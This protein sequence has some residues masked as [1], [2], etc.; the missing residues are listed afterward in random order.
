MVYFYRYSQDVEN[1]IIVQVFLICLSVLPA[2]TQREPQPGLVEMVIRDVSVS[3]IDTI[4][5]SLSKGG[6]TA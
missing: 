3:Q 4:G 1:T 6:A 5:P 2:P